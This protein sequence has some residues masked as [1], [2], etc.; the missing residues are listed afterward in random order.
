MRGPDGTRQRALRPQQV[1]FCR[2]HA[3][4]NLDHALASIRRAAR[5]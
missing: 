3:I 4:L 5:Y 2:G 1:G